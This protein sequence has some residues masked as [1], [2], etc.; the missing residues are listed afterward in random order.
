MIKWLLEWLGLAERP[1][2]SRNADKAIAAI[3]ILDAFRQE[4]GCNYS[5]SRFQ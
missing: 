3:L 4:N 1:A 5:T 2:I